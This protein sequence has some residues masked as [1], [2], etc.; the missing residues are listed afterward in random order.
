MTNLFLSLCRFHIWKKQVFPTIY[1]L[2]Y[3]LFTITDLYTTYLCTPNL[4]IET[5]PVIRYFNWGWTGL[6]LWAFFMLVVTILSA[7][8]ANKYILKYFENKKQ[9]ILANKILFC[10]FFLLLAYCYQNLIASFEASINNYLTYRY[11]FSNSKDGLQKI[12]VDYVQLYMNFNKKFGANSL[13]YTITI[14]EYLLGGIIAIFQ[15][16]RVKK[17][18]QPTIS[19]RNP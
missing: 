16:N 15:I 10:I 3:V 8:S 17:Y 19:S 9:N 4:K 18:A 5:N 11:L 2:L 6:L 13:I 12:A 1:I 14:L 7:I